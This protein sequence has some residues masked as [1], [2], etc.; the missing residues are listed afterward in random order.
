MQVSS[1]H[2]IF[3]TIRAC[4]TRRDIEVVNRHAASPG[5]PSTLRP[6]DPA[7]RGLLV[8]CRLIAL[9]DPEDATAAASMGQAA[10]NSRDCPVTLKRAGGAFPYWRSAMIQNG[11]LTTAFPWSTRDC[12]LVRKGA[13]PRIGMEPRERSECEV[14]RST[15]EQFLG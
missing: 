3:A 13:V 14:A 2:G 12:W 4:S 5:E 7:W 8:D 9:T 15:L 11:Q 6:R 10:A 1:A